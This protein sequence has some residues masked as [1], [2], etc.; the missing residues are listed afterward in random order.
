MIYEFKLRQLSFWWFTGCLIILSGCGPVA[1]KAKQ[2]DRQMAEKIKAEF[3]RS[4]NGYKTYAWP[5][6]VLLPVSKGHMD[7]YEQS[8][9]ISP[10]DAYST[11]KVMGLDREAEEV[12]RY[13]VDSIDF[14]KDIFVKTFE[15][16]I[17]I[18]G[19]LL[20]M[21]QFTGDDKVLAKA[22]DFGRRLLPSL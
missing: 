2:A 8:L 7:W 18:L 14:S 3:V 13:V 11:M 1:D 15:V 21:Y 17:R 9:H 22:E 20:A 4:W 10:I 16:N 19:G 5:H 12:Q 6:D